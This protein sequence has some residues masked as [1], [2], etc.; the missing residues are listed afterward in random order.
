MIQALYADGTGLR[1]LTLD[2]LMT[3]D[4]QRMD[5]GSMVWV[6]CVSPT[7]AEEAQLFGSW[8]HVHD[9]VR[10][11][12]RRALD[13]DDTVRRHHP[14]VEAYDGYLYVIANVA[15]DRVADAFVVD[16]LN[17]LVGERFLVTHHAQA[18][19][20]VDAVRQQC[21]TSLRL[22]QRGPDYILHLLLDEVVDRYYPLVAVLE[23]RLAA[24]ERDVFADPN[25]NRLPELLSTKRNLQEMRRSIVYQREVVHRLSRGE[26]DLVSVDESAYYRNVYDHLVRATDQVDAAREAAQA[27][28]ETYF[29]V[30]NARL[31][32]IM[33]M[34]TVI[35]T[36]FL[37]LTF[38]CSI[39][40]MNF[41]VMPELRWQ[42]GYPV[43]WLCIVTL[44]I[45]MLLYV[46]R[47]GWLA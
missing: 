27:L 7:D 32:Q 8:L 26:F 15:T 46:R 16:Q 38:L 25:T 35:S 5:D 28:T 43:F 10:A 18:L 20:V 13:N 30:G 19:D 1:T 23:E 40:G 45:G 11:D 2:E 47:K 14:K 37:P 6:D 42:Y 39:Y 12:C 29:S 24:M 33:R 36:I 41:D 31:N 22:W 4:P 34:L 17:V 9:L 3:V 44:A 21:G